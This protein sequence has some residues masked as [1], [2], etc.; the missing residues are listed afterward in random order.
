[1]FGAGTKLAQPTVTGA[2]Q[3]IIKGADENVAS[4][5]VVTQG[6]PGKIGAKETAGAVH[7]ATA[8]AQ[9]APVALQ[10]LAFTV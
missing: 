9:I 3:V 4:A 1:M 7:V 10:T 5:G 6:V 2:G 8:V